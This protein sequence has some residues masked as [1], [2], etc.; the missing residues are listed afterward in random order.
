[1]RYRLT[2]VSVIAAALAAAGLVFALSQNDDGPSE[3]SQPELFSEGLGLVG[4]FTATAE[5]GGAALDPTAIATPGATSSGPDPAST[6]E[7]DDQGADGNATSPEGA[8]LSTAVSAEGDRVTIELTGAAPGE[9]FQVTVDGSPVEAPGATADSSGTA[10]FELSIPGGSGN[11]FELVVTGPELGARSTRIDLPVT[12]PGIVVNPEMPEPGQSV[13]IDAD[14]FQPGEKLT[15]TFGGEDLASGIAGQDGSFSM[16]TGLPDL[17]VPSS[18]MDGL[19][20]EGD[21]GS[22]ATTDFSVP[23]NPSAGGPPESV[24][25]GQSATVSETPEQEPVVA[26]SIPSWIYIAIGAI[27]AWLAIL[28]LWVYRLDRDREFQFKFLRRVISDLTSSREPAIEPTD[29]DRSSRADGEDQA[30]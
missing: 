22:M 27:A 3:R 6:S 30:A 8:Q 15:I 1:M 18:G 29:E 24:G 16:T 26:D 21:R 12:Q 2:V 20:V 14:G 10:V 28:T 13:T 4:A 7:R 19:R 11:S 25:G 17:P 23:A 5:A 9:A